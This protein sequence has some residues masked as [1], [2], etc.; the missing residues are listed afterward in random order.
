[1][2]GLGGLVIVVGA[3]CTAVPGICCLK[4]CVCWCLEWRPRWCGCISFQCFTC[5]GEVGSVVLR[6]SNVGVWSVHQ[7]CVCVCAS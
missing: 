1:M 5:L 7:N 3:V 2:G 4:V 6:L